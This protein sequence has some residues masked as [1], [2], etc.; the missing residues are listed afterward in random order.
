MIPQDGGLLAET[1]AAAAGP[2]NRAWVPAD[3]DAE[4]MGAATAPAMIKPATP[5]SIFFMTTPL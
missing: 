2:P 1:D 4:A 5:V 3:V